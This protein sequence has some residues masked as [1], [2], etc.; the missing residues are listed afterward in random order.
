MATTPEE[1]RYSKTHEW[2]RRD[3]DLVTVGITDFAQ[4]QLGDVIYVELP[5]P[6]R[7]LAQGES[8]GAVDS[9]KTYSELFSPLSGEVA[10]VNAALAEKPEV[11]NQS[12]YEDGWM[13]R[14]RPSKPEEWDALLD[15]TG[16]EKHAASEAH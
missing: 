12:P 13:L 7:T 1:L 14:L 5:Q 2:A 6:G 4:D 15:A 11:I 8:F 16:Y 10:E 3:G 9:V